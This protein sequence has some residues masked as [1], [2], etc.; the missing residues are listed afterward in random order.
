[1][2]T[3]TRREF[4][5]GAGS[6]LVL[7]GCGG[8][9]AGDEEASG[10][11]RTVEHKHGSTEVPAVPERVVTVGLSD[12][13]YVLALGFEPVGVTDW[14]G[15]YPHATWPWAQDE[16]GDATP[17]VMPRNNDEFDFE[18]IAALEPDLIVGMYSGMTQD[19]YETLSE[20]APTVAQ[21]GE[22]PDYGMPWQATTRMAGRAL[23]R[24]ERAERSTSPPA[25]AY[26]KNRGGS[27]P[28]M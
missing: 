18:K 24:R 4:L 10:G 11:T 7:G 6:L 20:I 22:Y 5:I 28:P 9:G 16:L 12:H 1:M 2:I 19:D 14:Y 15:G 8:E 21:S 3:P 17:E 27:L 25:S 26:P 23:G 13:D